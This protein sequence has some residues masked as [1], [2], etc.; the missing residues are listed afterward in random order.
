[1]NTQREDFYALLPNTPEMPDQIYIG[2]TTRIRRRK[3]VFQGALSFILAGVVTIGVLVQDQL[4]TSQANKD[5]ADVIQVDEELQIV[6][7]Y[8][9]GSNLEEEYGHYAVLNTSW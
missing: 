6:R 4:M 1:M 8:L 5:T 7:D 3:L 9:N 2:V